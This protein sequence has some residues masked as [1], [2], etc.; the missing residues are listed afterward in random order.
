MLIP[1]YCIMQKVFKVLPK[2]VTVCYLFGRE[3][4]LLA[5]TVQFRY[6]VVSQN[7]MPTCI[8]VS[9]PKKSNHF[10]QSCLN[11]VIIVTSLHVLMMSPFM[12]LHVTPCENNLFR[13]I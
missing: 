3:L 9:I 12:K 1:K 7:S 6:V 4:A 8:I 5:Y 13:F 2:T 11:A 10:Y